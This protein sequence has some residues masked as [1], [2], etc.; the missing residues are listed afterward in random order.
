MKI[1]VL[2]GGGR[3]GIDLFQ[4]LLDEMIDSQI[5]QFPGAFFLDDFLKII[6]TKIKK[7]HLQI[8][9]NKNKHFF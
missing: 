7:N 1:V 2:I 8:F 5:V 9:I 4:S 3:T 6:N